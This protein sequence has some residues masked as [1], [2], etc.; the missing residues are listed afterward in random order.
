VTTLAKAMGTKTPDLAACDVQGADRL[1]EAKSRID[2]TAA[3]Y[4]T[5]ITDLTKAVEAVNKSDDAKTLKDTLSKQ[6]KA[7]DAKYKD[8]D[9][10]VK[11]D[12]NR[13]D[14]K[15]M[16]DKAAK[17]KDGTDVKTMGEQ[18]KQ[19]KD[20]MGKVDASVKA[21]QDAERKAA[22]EQ[23]RKE[24]EA[25]AAANGTQQSYTAPLQSYTPQ[26]SA[27]STPQYTA[28]QQAAPQ[29]STNNGG[30][31]SGGPAEVLGFSGGCGAD[32]FECSCTYDGINHNGF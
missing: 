3:W 15:T 4:D 29:H 20:L 8:M 13:K 21:K 18:A 27:P 12:R 22:E 10:K 1:D 23:A 16:I 7:A 28:P 2:E 26:Y 9:G 24:A 25:Q 11:D 19:L 5:H 14:L 32:G 17:T 6:V 31:S 30:S